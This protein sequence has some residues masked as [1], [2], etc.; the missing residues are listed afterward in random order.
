MT[1]SGRGCLSGISSGSKRA[2][3]FAHN[4]LLGLLGLLNCNCYWGRG[5]FCLTVGTESL[6]KGALGSLPPCIGIA[7]PSFPGLHLGHLRE[8]GCGVNSGHENDMRPVFD[9]PV[10]LVCHVT[11]TSRFQNVLS[12]SQPFRF[13][14]SRFLSISRTAMCVTLAGI[15]PV[16]VR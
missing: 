12:V 13:R 15:Y 14:F 9:S 16:V 8:N 1:G 2:F 3:N 4:E 10:R 5:L 11:Y 6:K 7:L